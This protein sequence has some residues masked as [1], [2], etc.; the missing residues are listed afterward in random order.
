MTS[1][2]TAMVAE[3]I[4]R[5]IE[6]GYPDR[7]LLF[8]DVCTKMQLKAYGGTGYSFIMEKFLPEMSRLA[9]SEEHVRMMVDNSQRILSS[10]LLIP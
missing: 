3:A 8:Q 5:L 6:A 10:P 2:G 4:P 9:V 7:I 1:D